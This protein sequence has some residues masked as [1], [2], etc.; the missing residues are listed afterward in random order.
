MLRFLIGI[1]C[2]VHNNS[3]ER[4][5]SSWEIFAKSSHVR[6]EA[7]VLL[8]NGVRKLIKRSIITNRCWDINW[9]LVLIVYVIRKSS[10]GGEPRVNM[11]VEDLTC[12]ELSSSW[13]SF[14]GYKLQPRHY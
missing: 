2:L 9:L 10:N 5:T 14:L 3:T 8:G 13:P 11:Q 1:G 6:G 7:L 12:K 4:N